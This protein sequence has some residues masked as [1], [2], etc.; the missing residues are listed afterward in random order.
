MQK[1]VLVT[2]GGWRPSTTLAKGVVPPYRWIAE[3]CAH[4]RRAEHA[5]IAAE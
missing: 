4:S 1:Q 5:I 2:G 3:K